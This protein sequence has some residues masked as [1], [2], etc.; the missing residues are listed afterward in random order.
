LASKTGDRRNRPTSSVSVAASVGLRTGLPVASDRCSATFE[1]RA[2]NLTRNDLTNAPQEIFTNS[3][4]YVDQE[5]LLFEGTARDNLTLWDDT[6][7]EANV[8][9]ALK[10][11]LIHE[12]IAVRAGNYDC[13]VAEDGK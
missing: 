6:V 7:P 12:E 8:S 4:A 11:A 5:I 2:G 3:V 10:D 9:R 1:D 13:H